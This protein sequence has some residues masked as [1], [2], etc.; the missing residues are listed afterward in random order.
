MNISPI[1]IDITQFPAPLLP[2]L[3][4]AALYDSSCSPTAQSVL[5][6]KGKGFFL[7]VAPL[8]SL[9][10]ECEMTKYFHSKG[11]S[12]RVLEFLSDESHDYFLTERI[13]GF[14]CNAQMYLDQPERL[15]DTLA[16]R[17]AF[18]HSCDF[19][20]CP[21][22]NRTERYLDRA[23]TN[24]WEQNYDAS[25][26][27]GNWGFAAPEEAFELV[28]SKGLSLKTDTLLHGDYCLPN[29]MLDGW[30]FSGFLDLDSAGVGDRHIDLFWGAWSL[31]FNLK[32]D[33]YRQR[34]F[35]AYGRGNVD[36]EMLRVVAACEVFE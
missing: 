33:K 28:N 11:L 18:L 26:F 14:D 12:T 7:K 10:L 3:S 36:E 13:K 27:P 5:I 1:S 29:I 23:K 4:G 32:T 8:G 6:D 15:C 2:Y 17:L 19:S 16:E 34:F 21:V 30:Q 35:D 31:F 25:L 9:A 22:P 20:S 24:Y